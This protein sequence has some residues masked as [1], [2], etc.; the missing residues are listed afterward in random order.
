MR[1]STNE[2]R[3]GTQMTHQSILSILSR[4]ACEGVPAWGRDASIRFVANRFKCNIVTARRL[5]TIALQ[6]EAAAC[7]E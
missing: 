3:K 2:T 6:C 5:L 4:A 1:T 7:F